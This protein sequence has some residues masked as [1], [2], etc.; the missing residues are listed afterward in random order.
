MVNDNIYPK[1]NWHMYE[2]T[3]YKFT[4]AIEVSVRQQLHKVIWSGCVLSQRWAQNIGSSMAPTAMIIVCSIASQ[5]SGN[6]FAK[7]HQ[8]LLSFLYND[9][10]RR[11]GHNMNHI[12]W[13]IK[14]ISHSA[15]CNRNNYTY[16]F[17]VQC[18][19]FCIRSSSF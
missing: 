6:G 11:P 12:E 15:G 8:T 9:V 17:H 1:V 10:C 19:S 3:K 2:L 18:T 16:V 4:S 13:T 14:L 5:R 7:D